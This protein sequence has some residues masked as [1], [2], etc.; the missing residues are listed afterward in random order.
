MSFKRGDGVVFVRTERV[1]VLGEP[2]RERES[3]VV[4]VV[5]SVTRDGRIKAYRN[6]T[7]ERTVVTLRST[8]LEHRAM[9]YRLPAGSWDM[10]KVAEYCAARPWAHAPEHVGAPFD[11]LE[12]ARAELGQFRRVDV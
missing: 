6:A 8:S 1:V 12:Q 7:C 9:A 4:G 10:C 5:T 3:V 2:T 11:G